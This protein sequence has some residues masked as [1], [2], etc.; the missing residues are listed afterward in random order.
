MLAPET[1]SVT[2]K[3]IGLFKQ[4]KKNLYKRAQ[5]EGG[6]AYLKVVRSVRHGIMG[7]L[8]LVATAVF[9]SI[10]WL[11]LNISLI[12]L[13]P[14]QTAVAQ[15]SMAM[16]LFLINLFIG[17]GL[18]LFLFDES[19]WLRITKSGEIIDELLKEPKT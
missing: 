16:G 15:I 2:E 14:W 6:L 3:V 11:L 17:L 4:A 1:S 8:G 18:F 13:I 9:L 5:I 10:S 7:V 12:W 19:R